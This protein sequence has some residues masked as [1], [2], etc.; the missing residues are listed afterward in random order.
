M[1]SNWIRTTFAAD[2]IDGSVEDDDDG[3]E[4]NRLLIRLMM[5]V[6]NRND[7]F[8]IVEFS[9]RDIVDFSKRYCRFQVAP[10]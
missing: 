7:G 1:D 5:V 10:Q 3:D 8:Y 6:M 4:S 2:I 9:M